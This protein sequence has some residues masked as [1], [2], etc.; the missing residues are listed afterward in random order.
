[1]RRAAGPAGVATMSR[2]D[3]YSGADESVARAAAQRESLSAGTQL[4][5]YEIVRTLG[6]GGFGTVYLARDRFLDR[7]VAVKEYLPAQLA[8]RAQGLRVAVRSPNLADTYAAGLRSFVNEAKILA[9][10]NHPAVVKVH[11]FWEAN[12]TA[13]MVMPW[14]RGP[15]LREVRRAMTAPP[16]EAWLRSLLD[17]LLDALALL[18]GQGIYHRD[19]APDNV[20]LPTVKEPVLLDFGAARRVV[21]DRTQSFTAVLKPSFAPIEQYAEAS[22]VR[23]GP[24]TDLYALGAVVVYLLTAVPPPPSTVRAVQDEMPL[25][26]EQPP[27]GVSAAFLRAIQW[28]LAVRPQERP[29]SV[30][31]FCN[32]LNGLITPPAPAR[33]GGE[34]LLRSQSDAMGPPA[35]P[36]IVLDDDPMPLPQPALAAPAAAQPMFSAQDPV[37]AGAPLSAMWDPTIRL[38]SAAPVPALPP[39]ASAA[40]AP[41]R[42]VVAAAL[43]AFAVLGAGVLTMLDRGPVASEAATWRALG[44]QQAATGKPVHPAELPVTSDVVPAEAVPAAPPMLRTVATTAVAADAV[45]AAAEPPARAGLQ[46]ARVA[47]KRGPTPASKRPASAFAKPVKQAPRIGPREACGDRNFFSMAIC[48]NRTCDEPRFTNH[49]QCVQLREQRLRRSERRY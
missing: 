3:P 2:V 18:H 11:R 43:V 21:G 27:P 31:E 17:P 40:H 36:A 35:P 42:S 8:Y 39:R 25:L 24:W 16:T 33:R 47:D 5:D 9:R 26:T 48:I 37:V 1:M 10:F 12:G 22:Q 15:T 28:A 13:Y 38:V 41:P 6:S 34:F 44:Q 4:D 32:A 45:A 46:P 49:P 30:Q 7:E 29:Q 19:I 23:Q 20:L 14:V